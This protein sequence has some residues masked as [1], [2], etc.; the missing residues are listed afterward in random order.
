MSD[1]RLP[2]EVLK[3]VQMNTVEGRVL[4]H[5]QDD[6]SGWNYSMLEGTDA[7]MYLTYYTPEM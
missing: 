7:K 1:D 2:V 4:V 5:G 6:Q 3:P